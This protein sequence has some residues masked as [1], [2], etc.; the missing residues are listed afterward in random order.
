MPHLCGADQAA[1][2]ILIYGLRTE[3]VSV[4]RK[5]GGALDIVKS[6]NVFDNSLKSQSH[7]AVRRHAVFVHGEVVLK[8]VYIHASFLHFCD[9]LGIVVYALTAGGDLKSVEQHVK[10]KRKFRIS[11]VLHRIER[12]LDR[13]IMCYKHNG[14]IMLL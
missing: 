1:A 6:Q 13:R 14:G 4:S 5:C 12:T 8:L 9:L 7:S 11:R 10:A 2:D 3:P